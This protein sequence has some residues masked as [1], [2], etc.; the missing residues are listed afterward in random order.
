VTYIRRKDLIRKSESSGR[1]IANVEVKIYNDNDEELPCGQV[2]EI[3][4]SGPNVMKGYYKNKD[5]TKVTLRNGRLHSGDWGF[6]DEENYLYVIGRKDNMFTSAGRNIYLEEIED[7]VLRYPGVKEACAFVHSYVN[8]IAEIYLNICSEN[9]KENEVFMF[10]KDRLE[11]YKLPEKI[12]L[13]EHMEKTI[14]GKI[15][16]HNNFQGEIVR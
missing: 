9:V 14:S 2:G 10:L 12:F 8:G 3:V 6:M 13:V 7:V 16:R 15:I 11:D 5:L 1:A 4:I